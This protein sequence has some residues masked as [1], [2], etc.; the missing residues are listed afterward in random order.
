MAPSFLNS[1][2]DGGQWSA[3]C[4]SRF[5]SREIAPQCPLDKRLSGPHTNRKT[6]GGG[7]QTARSLATMKGEQRHAHSEAISQAS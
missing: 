6:R 1:A 5:I 2:L 3:S 7:A 4:S